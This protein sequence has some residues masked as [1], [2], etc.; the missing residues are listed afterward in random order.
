LVNPETG[1]SI[2]GESNNPNWSTGGR[3][4]AGLLDEFGKWRESDKSAWTAAGD[5]TPCRIALSTPFGAGGQYYELVTGGQLNVLVTHWSLHPEKSKGLACQWPKPE[6]A[7][8]TVD[9][10]NWV[11]LTSIWYE[12]ESKRRTPSAMAQELDMSFVGSGNPV[13]EGKALQRVVTLL[14]HPISPIAAYEY[15]DGPIFE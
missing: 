2:T 8:E 6:N 12:A 11:G 10:Y 14:N 15:K 1:A 13:F 9:S 5:A 4:L 7:A 3:Y